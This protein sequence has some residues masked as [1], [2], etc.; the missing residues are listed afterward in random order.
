MSRNPKSKTAPGTAPGAG[1]RIR[2]ASVPG[3]SDLAVNTPVDTEETDRF[4]K[5]GGMISEG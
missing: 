3:H 5:P 1:K 2:D 4:S